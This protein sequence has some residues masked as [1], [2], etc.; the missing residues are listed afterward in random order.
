VK[1][2]AV[3]TAFAQLG[4]PLDLA[5]GIGL[6]ELVCVVVYV[7]PRTS[8]SGAILLTGYLGGAVAS[9]LRVGHS[10]F[11]TIFPVI[12]GALVWGGLFL[13]EAGCAQSCR[14]LRSGTRFEL[15]SLE[16]PIP[17]EYSIRRRPVTPAPP[18]GPV[19]PASIVEPVFPRC[20][21]STSRV[22]GLALLPGRAQVPLAVRVRHLLG[23]PSVF[24][25][26]AATRQETD[27]RTT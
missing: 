5:T 16:A 24:R 17:R 20:W 6:L 10:F 2:P 7:L 21:W 12:V 18:K 26:R 15:V 1:P 13:R 3:A 23:D 22:S 19:T 9:E 8:V 11:E 4:Y 27:R 14:F 25:R